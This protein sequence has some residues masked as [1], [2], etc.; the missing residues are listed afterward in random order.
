MVKTS[1]FFSP[2]APVGTA[3]DQKDGKIEFH[4][5][6]PAAVVAALIISTYIYKIFI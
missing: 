2:A 1:K 3:G 6:G 5:Y 4:G